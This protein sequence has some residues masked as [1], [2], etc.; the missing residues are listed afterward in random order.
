MKELYIPCCFK[1]GRQSWSSNDCWSSSDR[2]LEVRG[3]LEAG[4]RHHS[5]RQP[6]G[7]LVV[8][9]L[10]DRVVVENSSDQVVV[11]FFVLVVVDLVD[12]VVV[13]NPANQLVLLFFCSCCC[14][15]CWLCCWTPPTRWCCCFLLLSI[16][17]VVVVY[18]VDAVILVI[19]NRVVVVV[20]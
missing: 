20:V 11:L 18:R 17:V 12:C 13:E 8:V 19:V 3:G 4:G 2:S 14:W 6:G 16:A 1:R 7:L 10:V 9:D 5:L 15:P